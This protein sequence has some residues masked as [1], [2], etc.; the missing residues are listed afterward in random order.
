LIN[1]LGGRSREVYELILR[2]KAEYGHRNSLL[3]DKPR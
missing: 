3:S 2:G 1:D